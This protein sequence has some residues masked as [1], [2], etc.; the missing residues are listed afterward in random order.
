MEDWKTLPPM[1]VVIDIGPDVVNKDLLGKRVL[2]ERY[3]AVTVEKEV[4]LC[5][6]DHI[7]AIIEDENE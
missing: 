1:G 5:L 3:G 7:Q 6:E 2:F 4:K